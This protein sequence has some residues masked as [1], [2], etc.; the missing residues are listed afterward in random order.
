MNLSKFYFFTGQ[1]YPDTFWEIHH[2]L[3]TSEGLHWFYKTF[4]F[5]PDCMNAKHFSQSEVSETKQSFN[6]RESSVKI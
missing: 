1:I 6:Y 4:F 2:T 5:S 3:V